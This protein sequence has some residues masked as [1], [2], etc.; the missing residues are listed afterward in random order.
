MTVRIDGTRRAEDDILWHQTVGLAYANVQKAED[1]YNYKRTQRNPMFKFDAKVDYSKYLDVNKV[2]IPF[3]DVTS[4]N[5]VEYR[6]D[7]ST[8]L[9]PVIT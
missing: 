7:K 2:D 1:K 9:F 3:V 6:Y 8:D 5:H 4:L